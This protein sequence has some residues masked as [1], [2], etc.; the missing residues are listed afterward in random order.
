MSLPSLRM[1]QK[2]RQM[3]DTPMYHAAASGTTLS[4][5]EEWLRGRPISSRE[6]ARA[7]LA[8]LHTI[9][10]L[11]HGHVSTMRFG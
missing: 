11:G 7:Y 4:M 9:A 5:P 2:L 1:V 3:N 6:P 8:M 10:L